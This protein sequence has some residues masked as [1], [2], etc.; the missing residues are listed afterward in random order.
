[1]LFADKTGDVGLLLSVPNAAEALV[2]FI[3]P[4]FVS[5]GVSCRLS[6]GI[7]GLPVFGVAVL[8]SLPGVLANTF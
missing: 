7:D 5:H 8:E 6:T 1:M 2:D 4:L 3:H